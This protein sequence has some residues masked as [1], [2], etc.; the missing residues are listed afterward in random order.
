MLLYEKLI[1][2]RFKLLLKIDGHNKNYKMRESNSLPTLTFVVQEK[3]TFILILHKYYTEKYKMSKTI[4]QNLII[5]KSRRQIQYIM[6]FWFWIWCKYHKN[7]KDFSKIVIRCTRCNLSNKFL[8]Q[9]FCQLAFTFLKFCI[10]TKEII[11]IY[12]KLY[13]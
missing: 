10:E 7:I 3:A 4:K 8:H 2:P 6:I 13:S 9:F 5:D 11:G 1:I 12:L